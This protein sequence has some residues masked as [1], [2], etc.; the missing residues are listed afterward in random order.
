MFLKSFAKFTGKHQCQSLFFNKVA[1]LRP[2]TLIKKKL[3]HKWF[4]VNFAKFLRTPFLQ[5]TPWRLL[6]RIS[7]KEQDKSDSHYLSV[8][9][10]LSHLEV[11]LYLLLL[12]WKINFSSNW[13]VAKWCVN[14]EG[15]YFLNLLWLAK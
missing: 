8:Q 13:T 6:L 14:D 9:D 10:I 2:A 3:W 11:S 12:L 4:S 1:R 15:D 5:N 7:I